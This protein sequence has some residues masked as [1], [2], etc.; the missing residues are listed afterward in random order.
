MIAFAS[1]G[2]KLE[3][4]E[5]FHPD[6]LAGRI[7]GM[8]D[9]LT[10]IEKAEE[11][12]ETEAA[13]KAT[14]RLLEGSFTLEDFLEQMQ[15]LKKMGPLNNLVSMMPGIPKATKD[16]SGCCCL[17]R[18]RRDQYRDLPRGNQLR[19]GLEPPDRVRLREQPLHGVHRH[20]RCLRRSQSGRR[21]RRCLRARVIKLAMSG[22]KTE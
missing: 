13:E 3:D 6:R 7:L 4:F 12:Y 11:V 17:L 15:Q 19:Q 16:R 14:S 8:G 2:E 1:T 10:L 5:Q 21:P 18:R 20:R 22:S 9:M